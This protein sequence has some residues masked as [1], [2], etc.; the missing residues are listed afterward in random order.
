[1]VTFASLRFYVYTAKNRFIVSLILYVHF[2][3]LLYAAI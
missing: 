2:T 3:A 1:M